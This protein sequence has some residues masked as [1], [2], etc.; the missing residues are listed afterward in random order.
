MDRMRLR[1]L[2]KE[3]QR[4]E[5]DRPSGVSYWPVSDST[6]RYE[7]TISG[8]EG[9]PYA[10]GNF[11]LEITIPPRYPMEPP[12]MKFV[13]PVYHPNIDSDGR[14]CLNIL[15]PPPDGWN[16]NLTI[17]SALSHLR[18]LLSD[19][20]P[21]DPLMIDIAKELES[22]REIF[23]ERAKAHTE[24]YA[25]KKRS[26]EGIENEENA[27]ETKKLHSG[28]LCFFTPRFP[29]S[30]I[31]AMENLGR[32]KQLSSFSVCVQFYDV[33]DAFDR[34]SVR[35]VHERVPICFEL[36]FLKDAQG[37][38]E[39]VEDLFLGLETGHIVSLVANAAACIS[40]FPPSIR[41]Q[42]IHMVLR[43][44]NIVTSS[45]EGRYVV[46]NDH[47]KGLNSDEWIVREAKLYS[48]GR[49]TIE[50][51]VI[52]ALDSTE[53]EVEK[54]ECLFGEGVVFHRM[55]GDLDETIVSDTYAKLKNEI[56]LGRHVVAVVKIRGCSGSLPSGITEYTFGVNIWNFE[57]EH[58][59]EL[60]RE[61]LRIY[62]D[63]VEP[64]PVGGLRR[65]LGISFVRDAT[66]TIISHNAFLSDGTS[67]STSVLP[68]ATYTCNLNSGVIFY[69]RRYEKDGSYNTYSD[70][71][72]ALTAGHQIQMV[73]FPRYCEAN[74]Q[75]PLPDV[76]NKIVSHMFD[77]W[78][79]YNSTSDE[80]IAFFVDGLQTDGIYNISEAVVYPDD[81]MHYGL[82]SRLVTDDEN[83]IL[84]GTWVCFVGSSTIFH[85]SVADKSLVTSYPSL[86]DA[87]RGSGAIFEAVLDL[88]MCNVTGDDN[89]THV[90]FI[91]W[92]SFLLSGEN[93]AFEGFTTSFAEDLTVE[94][95]QIDDLAIA[96][97]HLRI[98]PDGSAIYTF[99][100]F[101]ATSFVAET[102]IEAVCN[103]GFG[104]NIYHYYF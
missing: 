1:R 43:H 41:D 87:F 104:M 92:E 2:E 100:K 85:A 51:H 71:K 38:Y 48:D 53:A 25:K 22:N 97:R 35:V 103:W 72:T 21:N 66:S 83:P 62:T 58:E 34:G 98:T 23:N 10:G 40:N 78:T 5:Q 74:V 68:T 84:E 24:K 93:P 79:L 3:L 94:E 39:T 14:I 64:E 45:A 46:V 60:T 7:G 31:K 61:I 19:P 56:L 32:V 82:V 4:Y 88:S 6:E 16:P 65:S 63:F 49:V 11:K 76:G 20:N 17:A 13:T 12:W 37:A 86:E 33:E 81:S 9:S 47:Y 30:F 75:P 102:V 69:T 59:G 55:T 52:L 28:K 26:S 57:F 67:I 70:L 44:W 42:S 8:P 101:S 54:V 73:T 91:M 15:K 80:S 99:K 36:L 18:V 89:S 50:S 29:Q 95:V 77:S 90:A 96:V 27:N